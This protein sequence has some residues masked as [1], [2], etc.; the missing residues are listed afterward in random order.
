[1]QQ[2][3]FA[4]IIARHESGLALV[5]WDSGDVDVVTIAQAAEMVETA[6]LALWAA[7]LREWS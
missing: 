3:P 6:T 2:L 1:M 4:T 7:E 5:L